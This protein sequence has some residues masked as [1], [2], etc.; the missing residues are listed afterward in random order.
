MFWRVLSS[1]TLSEGEG[2]DGSI[3]YISLGDAIR[4]SISSQGGARERYQQVMAPI[5]TISFR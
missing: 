4:S 3:Q 1:L 5:K 2:G